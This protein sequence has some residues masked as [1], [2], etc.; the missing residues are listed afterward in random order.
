MHNEMISFKDNSTNKGKRK[1]KRKL[2]YYVQY[3]FPVVHRPTQMGHPY[4][5]ITIGYLF[6]LSTRILN[7]MNFQHKGLTRR[8]VG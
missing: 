5:R 1:R 6:R 4:F 3:S 2:T 8:K 7:M